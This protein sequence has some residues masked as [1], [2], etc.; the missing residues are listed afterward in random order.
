MKKFKL[1]FLILP[2]LSVLCG[3]PHRNKVAITERNASSYFTL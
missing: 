1:P 3:S 2:A